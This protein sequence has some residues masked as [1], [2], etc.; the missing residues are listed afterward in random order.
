MPKFKCKCGSE[1]RYSD[2]PCEIEYKF[3]SDI[4]YDKYHGSVDT[5][6]LYL[7]MKSFIKCDNCKRLWVFWNGY[8]NEPTEYVENN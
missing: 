5:E 8:K 4:D 2:I 6:E 3:I 7:K 1:L